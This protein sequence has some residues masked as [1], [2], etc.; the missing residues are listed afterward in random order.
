MDLRKIKKLIELV[1]ESDVVEIEVKS[2]EESV[3]IVRQDK[4]QGAVASA[5]LVSPEHVVAGPDNVAPQAV[6]QQMAIQ[7]GT[8]PACIV[9]A[10]LTGTFYRAPAP[11]EQPFVSV[12]QQVQ[13]GD[14]LCIIESMKM[15]NQI[16]A[17]QA[18]SVTAV[19]VEDG[20]PIQEEQA[21]FT[22]E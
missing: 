2:G 18:G 20:M 7:P 11:G 3:R 13:V 1:E 22:I 5:S 15:M 10:P 6:S 16:E 4:T 17:E 12:G 9:E 8:D 19:L 21:L 14:V